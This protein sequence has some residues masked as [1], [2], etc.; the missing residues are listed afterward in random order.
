MDTWKKTPLG[1]SENIQPYINLIYEVLISRIMK[2][3]LFINELVFFDHSKNLNVTCCFL[4]QTSYNL[5][6]FY[7]RQVTAYCKSSLHGKAMSS[8]TVLKNSS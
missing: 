4:L 8:T 1:L 2:Y 3:S 7:R 5:G 6:L